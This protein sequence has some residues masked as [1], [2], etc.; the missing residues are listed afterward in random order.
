M[1]QSQTW[2]KLLTPENC[3][4]YIKKVVSEK[5]WEKDTSVFSKNQK[6]TADPPN[7]TPVF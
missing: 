5:L 4:Y 7:D 6:D 3:G 2:R 1:N